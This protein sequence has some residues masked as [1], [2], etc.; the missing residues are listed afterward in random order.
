[1]SKTLTKP[2]IF[3]APS[4]ETA[5]RIDDSD[6]EIPDFS[7]LTVQEI[8]ALLRNATVGLWHRETGAARD[9]AAIFFDQWLAR[10]AEQQPNWTPGGQAA[11][12][13]HG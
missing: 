6:N 2:A 10:L 11:G 7:N 13:R 9:L 4:L 3:G 1:M 8:S 5:Q 12:V